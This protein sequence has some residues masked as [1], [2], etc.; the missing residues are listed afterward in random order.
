M[1]TCIPPALAE[2]AAGRD[3]ITTREA[4]FCLGLEAGTLQRW[5]RRGGPIRPL[6]VGSRLLWRVTDIAALLGGE[7]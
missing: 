3:L 6:K 1:T 2:M 7:Q 5:P 4:A